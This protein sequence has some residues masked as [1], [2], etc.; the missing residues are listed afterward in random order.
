MIG[1][2]DEVLVDILF[3]TVNALLAMAMIWQT[4]RINSKLHS[5]LHYDKSRIAADCAVAIDPPDD[6]A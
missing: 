5:E 4:S 1:L 3:G 2:S 6:R